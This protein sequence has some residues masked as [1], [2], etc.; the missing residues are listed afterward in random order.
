MATLMRGAAPKIKTGL[1]DLDCI[2]INRLLVMFYQFHRLA[3]LTLLLISIVKK[4][5]MACA[6][7]T[8]ATFRPRARFRF[9]RLRQ[10]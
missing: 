10:R 6:A 1:Y 5:F 9:R 2:P 3:F 8:A 4:F 7:T